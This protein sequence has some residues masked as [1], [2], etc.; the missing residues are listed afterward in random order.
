MKD[1]TSRTKTKKKG[2]FDSLSG[3]TLKARSSCLKL[4]IQNASSEHTLNPNR[5][6]RHSYL[7]N[8]TLIEVEHANQGAENF[9]IVVFAG[10][11]VTATMCRLLSCQNQI[12]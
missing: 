4:A 8:G 5:S 7:V 12:G 9:S 11:S 10:A 3:N 6:S 2:D 1:L